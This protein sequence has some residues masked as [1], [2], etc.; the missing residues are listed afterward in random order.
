MLTPLGE[1][2]DRLFRDMSMVEAYDYLRARR[3]RPSRRA[4]LQGA[5][6][7][8]ASTLAGP[9]LWRQSAVAATASPPQGLHLAHGADPAREVTV[10]WSTLGGSPAFRYGPVGGGTTPAEP[11]ATTVAGVVDRQYHHVALSNL[12][13]ATTYRYTVTNSEHAAAGTF[14]TPSAGRTGFRFA[15]LGDMGATAGGAEITARVAQAAPDLV[16]FVGDLCYADR[17]G[18][19]AEPLYTTG[20]LPGQQDLAQWDNWL[21]QIQPSAHATPWMFT[22]GNHEMEVGQ[23]PLGYDGFLSRMRLPSRTGAP[24]Y[25]FR[26]G[27]VGFVA[28]D[29]NDV[30]F[31]ITHNHGY[32]GTA[33]DEWLASTLSALRADPLVDFI[34][35]GF[36]HC[37]YCSNTVHGSDDGPRRR[38]GHLFDAHGVDLVVN[39]HN[40]S[41]ERTH[42]VRAGA[43]TRHDT[44]FAGPLADPPVISPSVDGTVYVTAGAGGQAAYPTSLHP[45]S[46]VTVEGGVRIPEVSDWSAVRYLGDHSLLVVDVQPGTMSSPPTMR[47]RAVAAD[48]D[49]SGAGLTVDSFV[50][51]RSR[52]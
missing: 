2:P 50:L 38:W 39:G 51:T 40:H 32:A 5:A 42:P 4:F 26:Y 52:T 37:A 22:T 17:L 30:S 13:P 7:V 8:A 47:C 6:G 33:Q 14:T 24:Y 23:G 15:A 35:V 29:A 12:S 41:Y 46:T 19:A 1:I 16:F 31:E 11:M 3:R 21:A 28:L 44:L 48:P 27:T 34:V 43:A 36:H 20:P 9:I 18:G 10:S 25:S 49:P 45:A